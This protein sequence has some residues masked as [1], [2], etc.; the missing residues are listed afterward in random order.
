MTQNAKRTVVLVLGNE[1]DPHPT[2]YSVTYYFN[3]NS[4]NNKQPPS[5][6]ATKTSWAH[7]TLIKCPQYFLKENF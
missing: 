5:T 1:A 6:I 7:T 4:N 2:L 3:N